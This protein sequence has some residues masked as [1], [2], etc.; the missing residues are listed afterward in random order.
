MAVFIGSTPNV[1]EKDLVLAREITKNSS[2]AEGS[3]TKLTKHFQ[4]MFPDK[5]VFLFNRGRDSLYFFLKQLKLQN[6][7]EVI[8][9]PFTCISVVAPIC[10]VNCNPV[11]VDIERETFNIDIEDL[12]NKL[13]PNT[14]V[15]IVQ[16]TFGN[17]INVK[18]IR[19]I[20][21]K[22]NH[23]R[24]CDRKIYIVEDCAHLFLTEYSKYHIG[25]Y[26]DAVFFSFAQDKVISSTQGSLLLLKKLSILNRVDQEYDLIKEQQRSS[27]MYNAKYILLW[28]RIKRKYFKHIVPFSKITVGKLLIVIYRIHGLIKK[29]ASANS[30]KF[31]DISK[32]SDIQ[33]KLLLRQLNDV[34]IFNRHREKI[35]DIY[36]ENLSK[37][38]TFNHKENKALLRYPI[39]L[40]N[41][42]E[43]KVALAKIEII[44]GRWYTSPVFPIDKKYYKEIGFVY[45][46]YPN[47]K[48]VSKYIF[49]LPTNIDVDE[50]TAIRICNIVNKYGEPI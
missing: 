20:V 14:R 27:A 44:T 38:F 15:I 13:T 39:L 19:E 50:K 21:D 33:A 23:K 31:D 36:N 45:G 41:V 25:E 10:W 47:T 18:K 34:D 49:N 24:D 12:K 9:Q 5:E 26:S 28:D 46:K 2:L 30:L 29:Q 8:T 32:M 11:Y 43:I 16:H 17:I 48:F 22:I 3:M 37:E 35:V 6:S 40:R 4:K 42:N 7:D 1:T